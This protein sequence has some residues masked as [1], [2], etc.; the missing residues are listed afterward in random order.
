MTLVPELRRYARALTGSQRQGDSYVRLC[1]ETLLAEPARFGNLAS[2]LDL[3]R[4]F[5]E[6]LRA[7]N[8]AGRPTRSDVGVARRVE[9]GLADLPGI[10]RQILLLSFLEGFSLSE[11]AAIVGASLDETRA[12]LASARR[13][14]DLEASVPIMIIED[15]P[16]IAMDIARIVVEM[17]H[18]VCGTAARHAEAIELARQT[19]PSLILADI[20]LRGDDSGIDAVRDILRTLD[21]PIIFVTGYPER[22][23]TGEDVEPAFVMVKPFN[24]DMLKTFISQAL[25]VLPPPGDRHVNVA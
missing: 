1:L 2:K 15:E 18:I 7:L 23:L 8:P 6:G 25:S 5:H 4:A 17:G 24:P 22:L 19:Q 10:E 14:L 21:I 9:H 20:Q 16:L 3:F 11:T 13:V 12:L